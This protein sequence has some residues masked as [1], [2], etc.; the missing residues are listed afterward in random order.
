[1]ERRIIVHIAASADGYIARLEP[2]YQLFTSCH[3]PFS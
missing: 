3:A 1:M 2:I